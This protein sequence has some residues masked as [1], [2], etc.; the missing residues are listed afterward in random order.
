[1]IWRLY[2]YTKP[3]PMEPWQAQGRLEC[4]RSS[5]PPGLPSPDGLHM[6]GDHL[7]VQR[8]LT[9]F[10]ITDY[11]AFHA[12]LDRG[13]RRPRFQRSTYMPGISDP[14]HLHP[15]GPIYVLGLAAVSHSCPWLHEIND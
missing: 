14:W 11:A 3:R 12:K 2:A 1:M 9:G 4:L 10:L 7:T 15:K 8:L 5:D 13:W 6:T